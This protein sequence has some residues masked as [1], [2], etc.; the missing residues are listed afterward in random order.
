MKPNFSIVQS[1][2]NTGTYSD[3]KIQHLLQT[4]E[5]DGSVAAWLLPDD[6][7]DNRPVRTA[8][9][10]AAADAFPEAIGFYSDYMELF[11]DSLRDLAGMEAVVG[12]GPLP[13]REM[14]PSYAVSQCISGD[15]NLTIGLIANEAMYLE[16]ARRYSHE[17]LTEVDDLAVD[18][19][20]EFLNVVNGLF[21]IEL[22]NQKTEAELDI[23]HSGKNIH[24]CGNHQLCLRIYTAVGSFQA[25]LAADEFLET[26]GR[27]DGLLTEMLF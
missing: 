8:V 24:P 9:L 23:P 20:E 14:E 26:A 18:S 1:L 12:G 19:V 10:R 15:F 22:A 5:Q 21:C 4:V 6:A 13:T 25:V 7:V 11:M 17:D 2:F 16:L 3:A 27:T